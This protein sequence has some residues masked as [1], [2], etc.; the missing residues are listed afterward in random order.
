[1]NLDVALNPW[2]LFTDFFPFFSQEFIEENRLD[3]AY[4]V[5]VIL[6]QPQNTLQRQTVF[7][8][9]YL[10][11]KTYLEHNDPD[12]WEKLR[13]CLADLRGESA[14]VKN[15]DSGSTKFVK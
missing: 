8:N 5:F 2:Y 1:M 14:E 7:I 10:R 9:K 3:P 12:L 13:K 4:K 11:T 6:M 15:A